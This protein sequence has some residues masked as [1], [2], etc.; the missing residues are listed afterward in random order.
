MFHRI[1]IFGLFSARSCMIL[2]ARNVSRRWI[3][4]TFD[5]NL[6]RN[7]ASSTALSPPPTTAISLTA[8]EEAVAGGARRQAVAQQPRLGL[9]PEH[10]ALCTGGDDHRVGGE[11]TIAD[12]DLERSL[13][14]VDRGD[15]LGEELGTEPRRLLA[16]LDHQLRAH[17]AVGEAGKVLDI[18]GQHQLAAGLIAT[19]STV[20]PR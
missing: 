13:A 10:Q 18:G 2:E 6:V 17:D 12:H 14:E 5:A 4:M 19:C 8:E 11:L 16:E 15:L 1:S 7:V 3:R 9:E 20:R